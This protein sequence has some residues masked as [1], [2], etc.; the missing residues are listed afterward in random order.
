MKSST[1]SLSKNK[2]DISHHLHESC[3]PIEAWFRQQ[4]LQS[5]PPIY[6]SMDIRNAGFKLAPV[7][8][9]LFPAGF[10]N[11]NPHSMPLYV[12]AMQATIAEIGP[13]ITRILLIPE[14]HTRNP[15]YFESVGILEQILLQAGFEVRIGS[16]NPEITTAQP[17]T[18][19]SGRQLIIEPLLRHGNTVTVQDFASCCILLN[20]DLSAGVPELLQGIQQTIMPPVQLGW[21]TRL[22]SEHFSHYQDVCQQFAAAINMD[23]WLIMP[24]FDQCPD[25]DFQ[26]PEG[27]DCLI[28]RANQLLTRI[29]K[30]YQEYQ[31]PHQPFLVVKADQG[32]YGMAVMMIN[33][34]EQLRHLNRKQRQKM[35]VIKGGKPVT[36]AIIQEGVHTFETAGADHAVAEPV[37]Y[38]IGRHVIGGFYRIHK[39]RGPQENLNA[40][41]MDFAPLPLEGHC[42]TARCGTDTPR[43]YAYG[44]IAR[45]ALLASARELIHVERGNSHD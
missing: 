40:P 32:T 2:F 43:F 21:M 7:D 1:D 15:F 16:L 9:N 17:F 25:V 42:H 33:D 31:I 28:A 35:S 6:S 30:K 39:D 5:K 27:Q 45:L 29:R 24:Y 3:A 18:L 4:W 11:L 20:N 37:I 23:P 13:D 38:T 44:V 19:A 10:N 12:Q 22:K 34:P 14:S 36:K 41:G 26:N 8:T